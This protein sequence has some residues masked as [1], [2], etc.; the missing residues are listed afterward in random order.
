MG[1]IPLL[2]PMRTI[3]TLPQLLISTTPTARISQNV[4]CIIGEENSMGFMQTLVLCVEVYM[5]GDYTIN[6]F[7]HNPTFSYN[8]V[9]CLLE[10]TGVV[11]QS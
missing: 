4:I 8:E 9:M 6:K 11:E 2:S 7:L 5:Q 10:L 3:H 1:A